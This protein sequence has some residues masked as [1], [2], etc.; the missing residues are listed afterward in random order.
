MMTKNLR[1]FLLGCGL[2]RT[3]E[4]S[5]EGRWSGSRGTSFHEEEMVKNGW[6]AVPV[7]KQ[8]SNVAQAVFLRIQRK[9]GHT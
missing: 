1:L 5:L 9:D 2:W 4:R 6:K 7:K 3:S 8:S